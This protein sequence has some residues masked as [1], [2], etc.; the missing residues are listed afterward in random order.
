MIIQQ[1][2]PSLNNVFFLQVMDE[3]LSL[4]NQGRWS[5]S[6]ETTPPDANQYNGVVY[7]ETKP[8]AG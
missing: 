1:E 3:C 5:N 7:E 2:F 6:F 8:L 4:G